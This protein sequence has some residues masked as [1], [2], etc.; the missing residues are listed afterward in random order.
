MGSADEFFLVTTPESSGSPPKR[1]PP[2]IP[3]SR[4]TPTPLPSAFALSPAVSAVPI[5]ESFDSIQVQELTVD[6]IEGFEDDDIEEVNSI[7]ISRRNA[8][9]AADLVLK[10]PSFATGKQLI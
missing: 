3:V 8:N 2:P 10:V 6:D 5:S 4:P 7:R 9:D 1:A